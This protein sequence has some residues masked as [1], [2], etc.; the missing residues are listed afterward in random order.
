[1]G[2]KG[3]MNKTGGKDVFFRIKDHLSRHAEWWLLALGVL[4]RLKHFLENRSL[5]LDESWVA[6]SAVSPVNS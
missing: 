3:V 2:I 6:V 5:W 1:M 4:L